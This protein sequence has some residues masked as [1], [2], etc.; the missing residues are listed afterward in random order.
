M[1]ICCHIDK[2]KTHSINITSITEEEELKIDKGETIS[3][4]RD[5]IKYTINNKSVFCYGNIDFSNGSEDLNVIEDFNWF[6]Y[7]TKPY[8]FPAN[9]DYKNSLVWCK[10]SKHY[11][12]WTETFNSAIVAQYLHCRIGKPERSIIFIHKHGKH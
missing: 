5:G 6:R 9:I 3:I 10:S 11:A 4:I 8:Y 1:T 2:Y 12:N 7:E